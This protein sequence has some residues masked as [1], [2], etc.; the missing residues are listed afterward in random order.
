MATARPAAL[1]DWMVVQE[2]KTEQAVALAG[3]KAAAKALVAS[4]QHS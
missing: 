2:G 3:W 1:G 4:L